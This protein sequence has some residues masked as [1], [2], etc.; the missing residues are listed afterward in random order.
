MVGFIQIDQSVTNF[1]H[2][3]LPH[4][5]VLDIIFNFLSFRGY[6]IPI[7]IVIFVYLV[8]IEGK[9]YRPFLYSFIL[10][11]GATYLL[12]Q[13]VLKNLFQRARPPGIAQCPTDFGFPSFHAAFA[14]AAAVVLTAFDPKRWWLYYTAAVLIAY[15]RLYLGCHYFLDVVAGG[16]CGFAVGVIILRFFK[17]KRLLLHR[18]EH[19]PFS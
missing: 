13:F 18:D 15:S 5:Q 4:T 1:L 16:L 14:F 12:V 17:P 8:L 19:T 11:I 10:T 9:R 2:S 7:W 3:M 6:S